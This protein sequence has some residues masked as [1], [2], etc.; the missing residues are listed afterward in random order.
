[1]AGDHVVVDGS[2][3]K[4]HAGGHF[5]VQLETGGEVLAQLCGKMRKNK[6]RVIVGDRVKVR[7]SAYDLTRGMIEYR[8]R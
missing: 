1:M 8:Y 2:V 4:E 3:L 7:F 6:I 5:S